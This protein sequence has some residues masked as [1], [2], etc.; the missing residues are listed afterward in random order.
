MSVRL[1]RPP[2]GAAEGGAL[3][4]DSVRRSVARRPRGAS[5]SGTSLSIAVGCRV[6]ADGIAG[7]RRV[8][9]GID[10]WSPAAPGR[11]AGA[12]A[13]AAAPRHARSQAGDGPQPLPGPRR[14]RA[15][16]PSRTCRPRGSPPRWRGRRVA[17]RRFADAAGSDD[18][19]VPQPAGAG[20]SGDRS[21]AR[22]RPAILGARQTV[23][24][25]G[26]DAALRIVQGAIAWIAGTGASLRVLA[27]PRPETAYP[28][29]IAQVRITATDM[30][31][32]RKNFIGP[33]PL[34]R[35]ESRLRAGTKDRRSAVLG[36]P[37]RG[38]G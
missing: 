23:A 8:H 38:C 7:H 32:S 20:R 34:R 37:D 15:A 24:G 2:G 14:R 22:A 33:P 3:R 35:Q 18:L 21:R 30:P 19:A 5:E 27:L 36:A 17:R 28:K 12:C 4:M 6:R 9:R 31:H 10:R 16:R 11:P 13:G 1:A 29:P 25:P 26:C